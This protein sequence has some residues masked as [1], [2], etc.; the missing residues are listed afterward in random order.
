MPPILFPEFL[1]ERKQG[2]YFTFTF[3]ANSFFR[4][5]QRFC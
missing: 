2:L 1:T 3:N 4:V 5:G